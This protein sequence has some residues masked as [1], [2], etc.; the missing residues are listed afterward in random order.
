MKVLLLAWLASALLVSP[1][2]GQRPKS[3]AEAITN[4]E[5][6]ESKNERARHGAIRDLGRFDEDKATEILLRELRKAKSISYLRTVI[7]AIGFTRRS[8]VS[9]ALRSVLE[10]AENPRI[11]EAAAEAMRRQGTDGIAGLL[12]SLTKAPSRSKYLNA[13]CYTLGSVSDSDVARDVILSKIKSVEIYDRLPLLRALKARKNDAL[14]DAMRI[15]I[16]GEK[17]LLQA[18]TAIAQLAAHD[19]KSAAS[20]A[21]NLSRRLPADSSGDEHAAVLAGLLTDVEPRYYKALLQAASQSEAPF[22]ESFQQKWRDALKDEELLAWLHSNSKRPNEKATAARILSYCSPTQAPLATKILKGMMQHKSGEVAGAAAET[23]IQIV[24]AEQAKLLISEVLK[25]AGDENGPRLIGAMHTLCSDKE[26]W[27]QQLLTLSNSK[28]AGVRTAALRALAT[29]QASTQ[30]RMQVANA[31]LAARQWHVRAA[32]IELLV[33]TRNAAAVP[34]LIARWDK[35]SARMREDLREALLDLTGLRF[36]KMTDWLAWWQKEGDNFEPRDQ[37]T[38]QTSKSANS[39]SA[40]YW[41]IPVHSDHVAFVVD[42]SGSMKQPF[43]TKNATRL[44]ESKKQLKNVLSRLPK[45]ARV[46]VI[47]FSSGTNSLFGSLETLTKKRQKLA[48]QYI[49]NLESKGPT[50]VHDALELAF[51][52]RDVDTIFLLTDGKPSHGPVVDSDVLAKVVSR[53]NIG[54]SIRIH[55]IAMG[56]K[57]DFL[58][59]LSRESGGQHVVAK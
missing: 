1:I 50:N 21:L 36:S 23:L 12:E 48:L 6:V 11:A 45:K 2:F 49:A 46:N 27:S 52:D 16:A 25:K 22:R 29:S 14:V 56:E 9:P 59:R 3:A 43:G 53:W 32:A 10:T 33:A 54:R 40:S 30:S 13:I 41:N 47:S 34:A 19:H 58:A 18:A 51:Q 26:Q 55:T 8:G 57:S 42:G 4:F 15:Q 20:L 5:K 28:R 24:N 44:E 17:N 37:Q 38:E 7:R 39:T 31:N 35:E